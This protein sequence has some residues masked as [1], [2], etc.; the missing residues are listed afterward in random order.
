MFEKLDKSKVSTE[1]PA[2]IRTFARVFN[3]YFEL[4]DERYNTD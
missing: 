3:I 1:F 4:V 2:D